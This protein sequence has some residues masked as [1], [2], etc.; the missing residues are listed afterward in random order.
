MTDIET[1]D[2][3]EP[4]PAATYPSADRRRGMLY[5]ALL[6]ERSNVRNETR[7]YRR[8]CGHDSDYAADVRNPV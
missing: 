6:C 5:P 1:V 8:S 7:E 4:D 2:S 3:Q